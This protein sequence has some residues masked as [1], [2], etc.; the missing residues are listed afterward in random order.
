MTLTGSTIP[1]AGHEFEVAIIANGKVIQAAPIPHSAGYFRF[2]FSV[3]PGAY[4]V[5]LLV[6][7]LSVQEDTM[8][9]CGTD[10]MSEAGHA[11][12]ADFGCVWHG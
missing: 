2:K 12:V 5:S 9:R 7:G 6:T 8:L 1:F 4:Y 11:R 10:T 3:P